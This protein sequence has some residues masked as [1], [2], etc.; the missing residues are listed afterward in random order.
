MSR[1][2]LLSFVVCE[3]VEKIASGWLKAF[4]WNRGSDFDFKVG[5]S[6]RLSAVWSASVCRRRRLMQTF[7]SSSPFRFTSAIP[8]RRAVRKSKTSSLGEP[9]AVW[10][11]ISSDRLLNSGNYICRLE[12]NPRLYKSLSA[13]YQTTKQCHTNRPQNKQ[14]NKIHLSQIIKR[15]ILFN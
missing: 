1:Q 2:D 14:S 7:F 9:R 6:I 12:W 5:V 8:M 15:R 13:N 10:L 4:A 11:I 3:N